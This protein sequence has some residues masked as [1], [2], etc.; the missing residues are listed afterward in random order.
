LA[1]GRG[2]VKVLLLLNAVISEP[3]RNKAVDIYQKYYSTMIHTAKS[4]LNDIASAEDAV[5]ESMI[6]II[7]NLDKIS[8]ISSY[9]TRGYIVVIVRNT[10]LNLL[11]KQKALIENLDAYVD[12]IADTEASLID[13]IIDEE[14]YQTIIQAI[15][16]L[17][18]SMSNVLYLA[19]V[20]DLDIKNIS[21]SL[22]L[23]YNAVKMR[24]S[25][26]RA[27]I[28]KILVEVGEFCNENSK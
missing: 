19:T 7:K 21:K 25:R 18:E 11:K 14:S 13:N 6:K 27:N 16:S 10:S 24:L 8:D 9:K 17:P 3:E 23:S 15:R 5:S 2:T 20:N 26:A 1:T 22:N 12:D 28:R 4:I